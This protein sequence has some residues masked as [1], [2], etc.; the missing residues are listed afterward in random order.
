MVDNN[1][2]QNIKRTEFDKVINSINSE[3]E[4]IK[5]I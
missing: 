5:K 4:N 2:I 1:K 3:I